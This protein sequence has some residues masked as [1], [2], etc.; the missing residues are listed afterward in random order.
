MK[1]SVILWGIPQAMR[2]CALVYPKFAERLKEKNV[3]AQFKLKDQPRGR[4]IKIE[5]GKISSKAGIH[6]NPDIAVVFQNKKIAESFLM[7]PFDQLSA[8]TPRRISRSAWKV[9]TNWASGSWLWS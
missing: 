3:I 6:A 7:P 1:L 5:N 8:S 9:R 4:W 2:T